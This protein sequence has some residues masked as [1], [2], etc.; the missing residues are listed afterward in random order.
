MGLLNNQ[1]V[2]LSSPVRFDHRAADLDT[3]Y[4]QPPEVTR[5]AAS[6]LLC[7]LPVVCQVDRTTH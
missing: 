4:T 7:C 1:V 3:L 2:I 5:Q 6:R